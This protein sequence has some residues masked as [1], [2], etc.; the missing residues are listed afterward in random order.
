[1][2]DKC[3]HLLIDMVSLMN[4]ITALER[5]PNPSAQALIPKVEAELALVKKEL[6]ACEG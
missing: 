2:Q 1:M 6:E 3:K 5:R 4:A